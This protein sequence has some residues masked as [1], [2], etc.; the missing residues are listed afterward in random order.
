M[1]SLVPPPNAEV[2]AEARRLSDGQAKPVGS[3][4]R[5][6]QLAAWVASCQGECPPRPL[7]DVRTVV[8]AGDHGVADH[9]VSAYPKVITPTIFRA[10]L[11]GEG[12]VSALAASVGVRVSVYDLGV[13]ADLSDVPAELRAY[14]VGPSR[15]FQLE[16]ALTLDEAERALAAGDE[17]AAAQIADGAQLLIAGDVGIG[18]TTPSAALIAATY[19]VDA[20]AVTGRGTGIDDEA[21]AH[22][23][24]LVNE[25][26]ARI[27]DRAADPVQR[28]AALGSAD[29]AAATGFMIGAARRGVPVLVDGLIA[30]AEAVM[31]ESLA[32]GSVA[33][34]AAGHRSPEPGC[35]FAL[36]RLG[37]DP[38]IDLGMRLGEGT[39]AVVAVP[40]LRAA[41]VALRE[42]AQLDAL[43]SA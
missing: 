4:G 11:A 37:L 40:I 23:T 6:E 20:R 7:D 35:S 29:M 12:G 36:E 9:G 15:P 3:L 28:L 31:A 24:A 18:N 8:F 39:G 27:G 30:C 2:Y 41:V 42:I 16:D 34:M 17:I 19:G 14:R 5:L 22:K 13:D 33:W 43:V 21:L 26:V 38:I 10:F 32:P 1:Y 25:G